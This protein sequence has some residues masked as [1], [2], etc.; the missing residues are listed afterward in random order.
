MSDKFHRQPWIDV[1]RGILIIMVVM[2]HASFT[3]R[4]SFPYIKE[5]YWFHMP[6]FFILSGYLLKVPQSWTSFRSWVKRRA[7]ILLLPYAAYLTVEYTYRYITYFTR[8]SFDAVYL[9]KELFWVAF[10]GRFLVGVYW[11][12]TCF[13]FTQI[14]VEL[15]F[16]VC[17]DHRRRWLI[18]ILAYMIAH[19]EAVHVTATSFYVPWDLDVSLAT[20]IYMAVGYYGRRFISDCRLLPWAALLSLLFLLGYGLGVFDYRLDMKYLVYTNPILDLIIPVSFSL[21][22]FGLSHYLSRTRAKKPLAI[23]G[24][25]S[26][27]IMYQHLIIN[28]VLEDYFSYGYAVFICVG[29]ILPV[30]ITGLLLERFAFTRRVFLGREK[31]LQNLVN[32]WD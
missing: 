25:W 16:M 17:K 2:G 24:V 12:V 8:H 27:P 30:L 19:L 26:M 29:L 31:K 13:F 23:L 5:I 18:I 15:L 14:L 10:G 11:F 22:I 3:D 4:N 20:M 9:F 1:A 7:V 6:A 28:R 21:V 32:T